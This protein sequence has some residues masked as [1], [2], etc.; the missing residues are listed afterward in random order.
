MR[1][2]VVGILKI[3]LPL[4]ALALVVAVF[5]APQGDDFDLDFASMDFDFAD[6]LRIDRPR[7]SGED[8]AGRP[9][10]IVS[11]WA[12]P[13]KPDPELIEL[14]PVRGELALEEGRRLTLSAGAGVILP[15]LERVRLSQGVALET[16]EGWRVAAPVAV[17]DLEA[18][19]V[20]AEG[21]V[22]GSGPSGAIEA[23]ALRAAR[24]DGEDYIWFERG[25]RL[26]IDPEAAR[27]S[28]AGENR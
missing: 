25:V 3:A 15:K 10:T 13:D 2:N 22:E 11:D 7:F 12:I 16:G 1:S 23:G 26:R 8:A 27:G 20:T 5:V 14:G 6:G 4:S 28:E 19:T 21:P 9:F 17:A 18:G 24:V